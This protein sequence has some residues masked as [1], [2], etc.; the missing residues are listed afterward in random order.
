MA[1]RF[2]THSNQVICEIGS[3]RT[4]TAQLSKSDWLNTPSRMSES[5]CYFNTR[6]FDVFRQT[7]NQVHTLSTEQLSGLLVSLPPELMVQSLL[8]SRVTIMRKHRLLI[9]MMVWNVLGVSLYPH[10]SMDKL[11]SKLDILLPGKEPFIAPSAI[12]QA[13]LRLGSD[14]IKT[15]FNRT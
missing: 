6:D 9:K 10:F 5:E 13:P 12:I 15:I 14:A 2:Q 4:N 1:R 7:L 8:Q 3:L 11:F